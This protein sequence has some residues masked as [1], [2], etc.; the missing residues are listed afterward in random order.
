V[1]G[2]DAIGELEGVADLVMPGWRAFEVKRQELR[3]MTVSNAFPRWDRPRPGVALSD[4]PGLFIAGDWVG[5]EGMLADAA[6][7]SAIA[8]ARAVQGW[9]AADAVRAA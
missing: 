4:A 2:R 3:G 1:V 8:A 5:D 6:A 7:A 9:I